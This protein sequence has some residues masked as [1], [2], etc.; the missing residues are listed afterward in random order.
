MPSEVELKLQIKITNSDNTAL[1]ADTIIGF[2]Q[3]PLDSV[4]KDFDLRIG[5]S[6]I[7]STYNTHPYVCFLNK[8]FG[9]NWSARNSKLQTLG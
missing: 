8:L 1:A 6:S 9:Y 7:T 3:N 2:V 5:Q 4:F